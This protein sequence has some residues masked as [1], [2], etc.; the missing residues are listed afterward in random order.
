VLKYL[1]LGFVKHDYVCK[2]S[3]LLKIFLKRER[4]NQRKKT[5]ESCAHARTGKK[6]SAPT[7]FAYKLL[8]PCKNGQKIFCP[9]GFLDFK[10]YFI[11]PNL[12]LSVPFLKN[13]VLRKRKSAIRILLNKKQKKACFPDRE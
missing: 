2:S 13:I 3:F 1:F 7:D 6:Y 4:K 12:S 5:R 9:Y 10:Y 8:L 11:F